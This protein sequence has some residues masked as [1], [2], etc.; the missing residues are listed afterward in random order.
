M[1]SAKDIQAAVKSEKVLLGTSNVVRRLKAGG[2]Q[3]VVYASNV[4]DITKQELEHYSRVSGAELSGFD[5]V[6]AKLGEVCGKPFG[7][8]V[9][10]ILSES[11]SG[12]KRKA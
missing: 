6:S 4:P 10:G 5:G 12:R 2:I 3:K 7:V 1:T 11:H 8:L 9:V